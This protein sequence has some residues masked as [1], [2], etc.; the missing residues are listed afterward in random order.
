MGHDYR[1]D[2]LDLQRLAE[3][4]KH[5][6]ILAL[7][8]TCPP[9][10]QNDIIK[11]LGLPPATPGT[12]AEP[13]KTVFFSSPLYRKNLHYKVVPKPQKESDHLD[14]MVNYILENYPNQ[15]GIVYCTTRQHTEK[16]AEGLAQRSRQKIKTGS[17]H[18]NIGAAEK[19]MLHENW[20]KGSVKVVCAT[21]AFGLGID[22]SDVR[23]V[24]HHSAPKSLEGYYQESGRAGRDGKDSDC[25]LYYRPQDAASILTM[26][27]TGN[28]CEVLRYAQDMSECRKVLFAKYFSASA[29]LDLS[30]WSTDGTA[31]LDRCGHCD[32]CVRD[33][34]TYK[35][36]DETLGAWQVLKI[37][38]EVF[39]LK[40]NVT[41]AGLAALAGG[42]RQAK[43]KVKRRRGAATEMQIDVNKVAGGKVQLT[44]AETEMLIIQLLVEGYLGTQVQETQYATYAYLIPSLTA[45]RITRHAR[46]EIAKCDYTI[47]CHFP[48]KVRKSVN[49]KKRAKSVEKESPPQ[50]IATTSGARPSHPTKR[51]HEET[52]DLEDDGDVIEISSDVVYEDDEVLEADPPPR[53]RGIH[54]SF[55]GSGTGGG[56]SRPSAMQVDFDSGEEW[57]DDGW[58]YSHRQKPRQRRRTQSPATMA[59][60]SDF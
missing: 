58:T 36:D 35:H 3:N 15:S 9:R 53:P 38:E 33:P 10:V 37:A 51:K 43:I 29:S 54:N 1:P 24:L 28:A 50:G 27:T 22:K 20:R 56:G 17:Y 7:S 26:T 47:S 21:I 41:I 39:N 13:G 18:S 8:A 30:A 19:Q 60:L 44:V 52:D 14:M 25:I 4:L 12:M 48:V 23:F 57:N 42:G 11:I 2:Y 6:P 16:V 40:G 46:G 49:G 31:A 55:R 34:A 59:D 32:N 5:I 45:S